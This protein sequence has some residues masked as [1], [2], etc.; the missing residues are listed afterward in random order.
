M[1]DKMNTSNFAFGSVQDRASIANTAK[2]FVS[3]DLI[4]RLC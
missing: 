2:T 3:F 1:Y 4:T